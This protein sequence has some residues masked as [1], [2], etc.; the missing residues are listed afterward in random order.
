MHHAYRTKDT[1][2]NGPYNRIG[3]AS[4]VGLEVVGVPPPAIGV[5]GKISD[6]SLPVVHKQLYPVPPH[7][8][9]AARVTATLPS[10]IVSP[11]L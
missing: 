7:A 1:T 11:K 10:H 5:V 8:A 2:N 6:V 3:V 9:S 4:F